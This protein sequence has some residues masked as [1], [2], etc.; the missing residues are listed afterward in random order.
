[1]FVQKKQEAAFSLFSYFCI[2]ENVCLKKA[3]DAF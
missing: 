3:G 2:T 1:M